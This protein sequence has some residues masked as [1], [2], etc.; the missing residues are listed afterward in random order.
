MFPNLSHHLN[1][2]AFLQRL[3]ERYGFPCF[4]ECTFFFFFFF[5]FSFLFLFLGLYAIFCWLEVHVSLLNY[6]TWV[7]LLQ[8]LWLLEDGGC[9]SHS[10][11]FVFF[12]LHFLSQVRY[13]LQGGANVVRCAI[14]FVGGLVG[15]PLSVDHFWEGLSESPK[16]MAGTAVGDD[17]VCHLVR[18]E[19]EAS[20][21]SS[22]H[23]QALAARICGRWCFFLH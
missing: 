10:C 22:L 5:F 3:L 15:A 11:S 23:Q 1:L 16:F 9:A 6:V 21:C 12:H 13:L 19:E 7:F 4:I 20:S 18:T 14:L 2:R 8:V 17:S